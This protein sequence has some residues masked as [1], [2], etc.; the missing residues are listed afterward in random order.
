M[1][2]S[3]SG[4]VSLH[5]GDHSPDTF[6]LQEPDSGVLE[7]GFSTTRPPLFPPAPLLPPAALGAP[8]GEET[9]GDPWGYP[10]GTLFSQTEQAWSD[11]A[12][13]VSELFS[14][15]DRSGRAS[16]S[17]DL[18]DRG[19]C[20]PDY[21]FTRYLS[22]GTNQSRTGSLLFPQH[23]PAPIFPSRMFRQGV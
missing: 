16:A 5:R 23:S 20:P 9:F 13:T 8:P 19:H 11:Q 6:P 14:N 1:L 18:W 7:T 3:G 10:P 12:F 4:L 2:C 17:H 21:V 22:A 15:S